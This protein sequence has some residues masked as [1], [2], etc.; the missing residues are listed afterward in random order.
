MFVTQL[1]IGRV[2]VIGKR[3]VSNSITANNSHWHSYV[4]V[5]NAM[6]LPQ[7]CNEGNT[8]SSVVSLAKYKP[9]YWQTIIP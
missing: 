3:K 4:I 6:N 2:F 7:Q 5:D 1:A 9:V 8:T